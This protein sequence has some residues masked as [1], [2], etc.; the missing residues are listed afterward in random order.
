MSTEMEVWLRVSLC[1]KSN[2]YGLLAGPGERLSSWLCFASARSIWTSWT[3]DFMV[4]GAL[5]G[6]L[7]WINGMVMVAAV[8]FF[9]TQSA[10]I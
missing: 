9:G 5:R 1:R 6:R 8:S 3:A 2:G 10:H 7:V 4:L